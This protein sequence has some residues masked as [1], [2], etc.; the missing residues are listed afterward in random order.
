MG[1]YDG[2]VIFENLE[3]IRTISSAG[4][5]VCTASDILV[6]RLPS[7]TGRFLSQRVRQAYDDFALPQRMAVWLLL[8]PQ[9]LWLWR[10]TK[11]A[12]LL[13][14][15]GAVAVA[16]KGR[17]RDGGTAVFPATASL[18]APL[19]LAERAFCSWLA[20]GRYLTGGVPYGGGKIKRAASTVK[21]LRG[22]T[23]SR[24]GPS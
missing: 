13:V 18:F 9:T 3:L 6:A 16:E 4:G 24:G 19:W 12:L 10:K 15:A 2:D 11:P 5:R 21:V 20:V 14:A 1:G 17:R 7:T 22:R 8:L 23:Q